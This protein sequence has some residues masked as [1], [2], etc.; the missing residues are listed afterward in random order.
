MDE[1]VRQVDL[2]EQEFPY[3]CQSLFVI[4]IDKILLMQVFRGG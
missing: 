1:S 2:E 4:E 3:D